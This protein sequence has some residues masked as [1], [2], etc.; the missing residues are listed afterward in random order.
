MSYFYL[1]LP[2]LLLFPSINKYIQNNISKKCA[3]KSY[4]IWMKTRRNLHQSEWNTC[5]CIF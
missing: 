1:P 2:V 5:T 3:L 4:Q